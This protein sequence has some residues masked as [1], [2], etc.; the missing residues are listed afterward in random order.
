MKKILLVLVILS[1]AFIQ[2]QFL[3]ASQD[4]FLYDSH[5]HR[6]PFVPLIGP[7]A[8]AGDQPD[9]SVSSIKLEG[10][11]V[12]PKQGSFVMVDGEVYEEGH[13]IG[14]Y[15]IEKIEAKRVILKYNKEHYELR[16][17]ED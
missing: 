10:I 9:L 7:G 12:D 11:V 3:I 4:G 8:Q 14:P 17:S 2:G 16:L 15:L 6:D 13:K 1:G 5:K